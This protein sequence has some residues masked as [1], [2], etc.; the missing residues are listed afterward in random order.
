MS[1]EFGDVVE[2][3]IDVPGNFD[4]YWFSGTANTVVVLS[5]L[6][7]TN[8][9][10]AFNG[11]RCLV[12]DLYAPGTTTPFLT[13]GPGT[14]SQEVLLLSSGTYIIRIKEYGDNQTESYRIGLERLFPASP[15]TT[16][17]CFGCFITEG[18]IDPTPDQ[19]FYQFDGVQ[20][21]VIT[22]TLTDLTN[23]CNAF[24]GYR[25]PVARLLGPDQALVETLGPGTDSKD[26]P[27][28]QTGTYTVHVFENGNNQN[29][30]YILGLQCLFLAC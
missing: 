11:Y 1:I 2:C 30:T 13:L 8:D 17:L 27:L 10:N 14:I 24:N 21:A 3:A 12:A 9:C 15:T 5:L 16:P 28:S 25:C 7:L 22:L 20:N 26:I 4:L 29:E 6:D 19:D 18:T 23:D